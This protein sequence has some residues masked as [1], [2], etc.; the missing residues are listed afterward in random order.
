MCLSEPPLCEPHV[1]YLDTADSQLL[2][3]YHYLITT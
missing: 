3:N 2:P 1:T